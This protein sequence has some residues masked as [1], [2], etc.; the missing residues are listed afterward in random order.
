MSWI[1][2][3]DQMMIQL[4]RA[5]YAVRYIKHFMSQDTLRTIYSLYF[6]SILSYG[7]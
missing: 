7:I 3:I 4:G 6:H 2:H 5:C 1:D